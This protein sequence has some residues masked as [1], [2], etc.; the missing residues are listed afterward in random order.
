MDPLKGI[1]KAEIKEAIESKLSRYFNTTSADA[2][3]SQIYKATVLTVKDILTSMRSSIKDIKKSGSKRVVYLCGISSRT[4]ASG[5][6]LKPQVSTNT[7]APCARVSRSIAYT[8]LSLTRRSATEDSAALPLALWIRYQHSVI[9]QTDIP[10]VMNTAFSVRKSS[11]GSR[12]SFPTYG[13]Q[14]ANA[15]SFPAPTKHSPYALTGISSKTGM[16]AAVT[17]YMK[18]TPKYKL[19]PTT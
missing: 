14:T 16:T 3:E 7:E 12:L 6:S 15:G 17:S 10:Y 1:T 8:S 2:S 13:F 4:L 11:T 19:F 5:Q 9:L 18:T